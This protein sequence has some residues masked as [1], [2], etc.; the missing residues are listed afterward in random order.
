MNAT[1]HTTAEHKAEAAAQL[2]VTY[3]D[4]LDARRK[5]DW[6]AVHALERILPMLQIAADFKAY[7]PRA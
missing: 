7:Q 1:I 6:D 4:V 2:H 3:L 5:R